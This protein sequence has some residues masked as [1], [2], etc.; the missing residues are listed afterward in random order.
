[1]WFIYFLF[2]ELHKQTEEY[3]KTYFQWWHYSCRLNSNI[4]ENKL[5]LWLNMSVSCRRVVYWRKCC[6][7]HS[8]LSTSSFS[9]SCSERQTSKLSTEG[10]KHRSFI[11]IIC[12]RVCTMLVVTISS[13]HLDCV[14]LY[15]STQRIRSSPEE[16]TEGSRQQLSA[17]TLWISHFLLFSF[18][19]AH[20]L[21]LVIAARWPAGGAQNPLLKDSKAFEAEL[22]IRRWFH[23]V[24]SMSNSFCSD[25]MW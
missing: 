7:I 21:L 12:T 1:M 4:R 20:V 5:T 3:D 18:F 15:R 11:C 14:W 24:Y 2:S 13:N 25:S 8:I 10:K 19:H 6:W 16:A 17:F 9:S 23:K 22:L